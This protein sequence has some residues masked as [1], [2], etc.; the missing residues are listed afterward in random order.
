MKHLRRLNLK[1]SW[2]I[3]SF[4]YLCL[5]R[6]SFTSYFVFLGNPTKSWESFFSKLILFLSNLLTFSLSLSLS[7]SPPLSI[8]LFFTLSH[9]FF[10]SLFSVMKY[11]TRTGYWVCSVNRGEFSHSQK[12]SKLGLHRVITKNV[13]NGTY[14]C[15]VSCTTKIF[16]VGGMHR[17]KNNPL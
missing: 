1:I 15:Y 11:K 12:G 17:P 16:K 8:P 3:P 2:K 14:C 4:I 13:K 9:S 7:L 5:I 10:S 6:Y